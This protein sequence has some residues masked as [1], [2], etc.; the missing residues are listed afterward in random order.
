MANQRTARSH[1]P[2]WEWRRCD[3]FGGAVGNDLAAA[4]AA[5]RAQVDHPVGGLDHVEIVLDHDQRTA[6]VDQF[7][8]G[9]EQLETSSK[10]RPV[11][12][13]SRM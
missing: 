12:G 3:L 2:V 10:C 8:E 5:F 13:S 6:A 11:V 4:F 7:A 9:G 1:L